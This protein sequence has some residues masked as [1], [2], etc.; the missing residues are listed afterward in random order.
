VALGAG[1]RGVSARERERRGVVIE[2][3]A[4]PIGCGMAGSAGCRESDGGV[5]R[6]V[7]PVVIRLV[8]TVA[9]GR[10]S[11]VVVIGVALCALQCSVRSG[12]REH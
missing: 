2:A 4:G 11:C 10:Q 12:Q 5:G 8:A 1:N 3:R 9:G 7:G 6:G